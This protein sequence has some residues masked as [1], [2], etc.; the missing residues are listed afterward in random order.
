MRDIVS[1]L[2]TG[3]MVAG[4]ALL[5]SAC[6]STE[7]AAND[8]NVVE[9]NAEDNM[10]DGTATDMM[11]NTDAVMAADNAIDNAA[12][13]VDNAAAAVDNAAAAVTNAN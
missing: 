8:A 13:A 5:V 2:M 1:K 11:T 6:G 7:P 3:T 4:A 9:L 12:T 10:L